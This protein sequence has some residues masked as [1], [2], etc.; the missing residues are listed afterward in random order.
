[1]QRAAGHD[2]GPDRDRGRGHVD[3]P[4]FGH[5]GP[6]ITTARGELAAAGVDEK[7]GSCELHHFYVQ[8][9]YLQ[10]IDWEGVPMM[11]RTAVVGTAAGAIALMFAVPAAAVAPKYRSGKYV[12]HVKTEGKIKF[13]VAGHRL[14]ALATS[15]TASCVYMGE[16]DNPTRYQVKLPARKSVA[17]KRNGR[18]SY[19]FSTDGGNDG[20][21]I[22]GRLKGSSVSGTFD[23]YSEYQDPYSDFADICDTG[24]LRFTASTKG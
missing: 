11:P 12:G 14:T 4:D 16:P 8:S 13:V 24:T 3:S 7:S 21:R 20:Y 15:G 5:L 19:N 23:D 6:M 10:R 1:M 2:P 18:F 17:I 9:T 22:T